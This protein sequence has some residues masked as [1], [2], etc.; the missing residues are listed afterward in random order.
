MDILI[1]Q[2]LRGGK[3]EWVNWQLFPFTHITKEKEIKFHI[4][5]TDS[6]F[7]LLCYLNLIRTFSHGLGFFCK[8]I[9]TPPNFNT[10]FG[11]PLSFKNMWDGYVD[12]ES[13]YIENEC[14]HF[15]H[16]HFPF[17]VL[18]AS[19]IQISK[20]H[21]NFFLSLSLPRMRI[22]RVQLSL[23]KRERMSNRSEG[24]ITLY[25]SPMLVGSWLISSP[26]PSFFIL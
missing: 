10:P 16:S 26:T 15:P 9:F 1:L 19:P 5:F 11:Y 23:H 12:I 22:K 25:C 3:S 14:P 6:N 4:L 21:W 24:F 2:L 13:A 8:W 17:F 20:A 7:C 18:I